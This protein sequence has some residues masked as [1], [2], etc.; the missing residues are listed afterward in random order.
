[1][2]LLSQYQREL[3]FCR[4]KFS[5][6]DL[7]K[8]RGYTAKFTTFSANVQ[9][10][11]PAIPRSRH[12]SLFRE[13]LMH[14][15]FTSFDQVFSG[16]G[17]LIRFK[18]R[19]D[20]LLRPTGPKIYCTYH[21]G[22]YRLLTSLLFRRGVDCVLL[23]GANMNRSQ[24]DGMLEHIDAL[25][26]QHGLTNLFRVVEA[27]HPSVVMTILRELKAGRSLIVYVDGSPETTPK[28][29]EENAFL[30]VQLG[31]RQVFTRKGVGYLSHLSGA[32]IVPVVSYRQQDLINVI[33]CLDPI[34]PT[35]SANRETFC[36]KTMQQL[37][38][39]FWPYLNRYPG[40]WEGWN[41]IHGFLKPEIP[42]RIDQRVKRQ[43][44]YRTR[45]VTR[46]TFNEYR[47]TLCDLEEAPVL[48]DR[49]CYETYEISP[50]LRDLL[51]NITKIDSIEEMVGTELFGELVEKEILC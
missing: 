9:N 41:F 46:P 47:Y 23:V 22:S 3:N 26:Q 28:P 19:A 40:Q 24:G 35:P 16:A 42:P 43:N 21:L 27:G 15:T 49:L 34:V 25:R 51:L 20:E 1:M 18:G 39:G 12:E 2:S 30:P 45:S 8:E 5:T 13:V 38:D 11:M 37:Y 33:G 6:I 36:T 44:V 48:F 10:I 31:N 14:G 4:E 29:G 17:D 32:T 50:D 7:H